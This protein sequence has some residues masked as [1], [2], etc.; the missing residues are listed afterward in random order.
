[1]A[2][3]TETGPQGTA[4]E[5][6]QILREQSALQERLAELPGDAFDERLQ[7]KERRRELHDRAMA[8]TSG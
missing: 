5:L 8:L 3:S 4:E 6:E 1:M 7:I 2:A